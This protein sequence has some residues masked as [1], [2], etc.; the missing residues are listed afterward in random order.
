MPALFRRPMFWIVIVLVLGGAG[1]CVVMGKQAAAKKAAD[2]KAAIATLASTPYAGIASGK[3]DVEGGII[4]VAARTAGVIRSVDVQEGDSVKKGQI[5][6]QLEDD[7]PRLNVANAEAAVRQ[8]QA[9]VGL[10]EVQKA[11]AE[12]E[13]ARL[14]PLKAKNFVAGQALDTAADAI[15][16]ADAQIVLQRAVIG[17]AQSALNVASYQLELTRVRAPTD[18]RIVRRY[19]NPGAGAS[20]LNVSNMFDLEPKTARIV[21]AEI[22]ESDIPKI[23]IGQQAEIVPEADQTKVY[24]GRVMRRSDEFGARKLQSD[25][26]ND[27]ADDRVVEVVVS[28]DTAPLLIGQRVLVKFMKPGQIAGAPHPMPKSATPAKAA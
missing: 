24:V 18:G 10:L 28:A 11:T 3:A 5:L 15:K 4:Q 14:Q 7:Q 27:K 6:A 12:R 17:T 19:A 16:T 8:A 2:Q 23:A 20:T 13:L 21:R 26:P 22:A 9:Q 1:A 25:D